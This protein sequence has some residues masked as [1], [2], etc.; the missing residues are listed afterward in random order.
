MNKSRWQLSNKSWHNKEE[1]LLNNLK[2]SKELKPVNIRM[3]SNNDRKDKDKRDRKMYNF[4][5]R[6]SG[7]SVQILILTIID[8]VCTI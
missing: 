5:R 6:L 2:K 8:H 3:R 7:H 4:I 1:K